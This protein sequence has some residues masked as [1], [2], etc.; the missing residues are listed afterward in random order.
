[1]AVQQQ[2][3]KIHQ[4][5]EEVK[6]RGKGR[7]GVYSGTWKRERGSVAQTA[8][9]FIGSRA[10]FSIV[11]IENRS[12]TEPSWA[13]N[14][15]GGLRAVLCTPRSAARGFPTSRA[16]IF[17]AEKCKR[18]P[19]ENTLRRGAARY[20]ADKAYGPGRKR[21]PIFRGESVVFESSC[22]CSPWE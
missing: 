22:H 7:G 8:S 4:A 17:I 13:R 12:T 2:V 6:R 11:A 16:R 1:M 3:A 18:V 10:D 9:L 20:G 15:S 5:R 14:T 21:E 19:G